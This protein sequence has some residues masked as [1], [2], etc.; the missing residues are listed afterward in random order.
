MSTL[1]TATQFESIPKE[2]S[3][4][5]WS[6]D[7]DRLNIVTDKKTIVTQIVNYGT[8]NSWKW[9]QRTYGRDG[10][11]EVLGV[12]PELT[13]RPGARALASI[14]FGFTVHN[15]HHAPRGAHR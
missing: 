10:V 3:G 8:W 5:F 1:E 15:N 12:L 2:F 11:R 13:L 7:I 9:L 6:Y 4:F 14:V